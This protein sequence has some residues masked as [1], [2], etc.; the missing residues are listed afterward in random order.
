MTAGSAHPSDVELQPWRHLQLWLFFGGALAVLYGYSRDPVWVE[1]TYVDGWGSTVAAALSALTAPVPASFAEIGLMIVITAE[2]IFGLTA[3]SEVGTGRRRVR[4]ALAGGMFHLADLTLVLL[5]WFYT[6][7]GISYARAP[8]VERLGWTETAPQGEATPEA[9]E[10]LADLTHFAIDRTHLTYRSL[11][12]S[13]DDPEITV[14]R[15]GLDVGAA[16]DVGFDNA[17]EALG[18]PDSFRMGRGPVKTPLL[19]ELMSWAGIGGIYMPFTGEANVNGGPPSWTRV[20]TA[21]HEKS[22]QR[23]IASEDE[24]TF[25]GFLAAVYSDDPLLQYCAW[26][27]ARR[28]LV[29]VLRRADKARAIELAETV[30]AGPIRDQQAVWDYWDAYDGPLEKM[31]RRMNDTYLKVN[32]V[33]GGVLAY[34]RA[35]KLVVAWMLSEPGKARMAAL[36]RQ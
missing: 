36:P 25:F 12:G 16:L 13:L 6:S 28:Q 15:P 33:E 1:Q 30:A 34:G 14:P 7:W 31:S 23:M 10:R 5:L 18:L 22:H 19:S 2:L 26:Q 27:L 4:N 35:D 3:L 11:H 9:V 29:G 24:A 20:L 8:A 21:A 17:G 32:R